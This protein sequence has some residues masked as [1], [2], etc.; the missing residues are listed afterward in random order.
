MIFLVIGWIILLIGLLF[1]LFPAKEG[2]RLYGYRSYLAQKSNLHWHYAQ[3]M[4]SRFFLL[5][6]SCM[7]VI[8][9]LLK[10]TGHT[11]FF[12]VEILALPWFVAPMFGFIETK[13]TKFDQKQ[14][15]SDE[16][17]ND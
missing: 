16:H 9:S 2:S 8:G 12:L 3:K 7:V 14:G 5:C 4:S 10:Y 1:L 11:N 13:L 6:G 17:F 15:D